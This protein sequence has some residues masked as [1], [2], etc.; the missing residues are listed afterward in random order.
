MREG[1]RKGLRAKNDEFDNS[2]KG[3]DERLM[4]LMIASAPK[5][6]S[7]QLKRNTALPAIRRIFRKASLEHI[8]ALTPHWEYAT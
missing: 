4:K 6:S 7:K 8:R 2:S 5:E 3:E 1:A